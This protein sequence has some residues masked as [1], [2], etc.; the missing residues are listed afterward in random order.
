MI[1]QNL[2]LYSKL[3]DK[4]NQVK[5]YLKKINKKIL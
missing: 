4:E 3:I 5:I 1:F 2:R